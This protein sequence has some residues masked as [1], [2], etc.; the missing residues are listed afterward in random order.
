MRGIFRFLIIIGMVLSFISI[1]TIIISGA[2]YF[3]E[4]TSVDTVPG[5]ELF[6]E[7]YQ[8]GEVVWVK[9]R[10]LEIDDIKNN[11]GSYGSRLLIDNIQWQNPTNDSGRKEITLYPIDFNV[12]ISHDYSGEVLVK[13]RIKGDGDL[14]SFEGLEIRNSDSKLYMQIFFITSFIL[15]IGFLLFAIPIC[16]NIFRHKKVLYEEK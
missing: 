15:P 7:K 11:D 8:D 13:I 4:T 2:L 1:P 16:I 14:R 5:E 10:T 9:G 3:N 6:S 12:K